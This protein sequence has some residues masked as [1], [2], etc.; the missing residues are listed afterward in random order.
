MF[1]F[2]LWTIINQPNSTA[3]LGVSA[4]VEKPVVVNGKSSFI[5]SLSLG[6]TI[7]HRVV[8]EHGWCQIH[9]RL[10]SLDWRPDFNVESNQREE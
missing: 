2:N 1:V 3:I 6:L 7:D 8:D 9:E 5:K 10:E 4:T